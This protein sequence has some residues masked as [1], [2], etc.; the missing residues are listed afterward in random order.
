MSGRDSRHSLIW[1][2]DCLA[3]RAS[4]DTLLDD[5]DRGRERTMRRQILSFVAVVA[6]V[7]P[8]ASKASPVTYD[9]T[10]NGGSTGPLANVTASGT[11]T[12]DSSIIPVGGGADIDSGLLTGV[13]FTWDG[14]S[15]DQATTGSLQ[16]HPDGSL[17]GVNI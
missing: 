15:Y 13:S 12:Y 10:V 5:L 7:A 17:F 2:A 9:F 14:I 4:S 3:T 8:L 6:L 16:F 11:F 1:S